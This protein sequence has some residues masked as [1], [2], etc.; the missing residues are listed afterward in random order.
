MEETSTTTTG[1][2]N[3][4]IDV[5]RVVLGVAKYNLNDKKQ[6]LLRSKHQHKAHGQQE[7][8]CCFKLL[9][10]CHCCPSWWPLASNLLAIAFIM[11]IFGLFGYAGYSILLQY[12][13]P[14]P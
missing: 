4:A 12:K 2:E 7:K 5:N 8:Y 9:P 6:S 10:S 1:L 13:F 3:V 11:M 14:P